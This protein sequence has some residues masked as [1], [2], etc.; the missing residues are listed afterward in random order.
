MSNERPILNLRLS[1]FTSPIENIRF[2][3]NLRVLNLENNRIKEVPDLTGLDSLA[4]L[5]LKK[6]HIEKMCDLSP[7]NHLRRLLLTDNKFQT[8][9]DLQLIGFAPRLLELNL[10][11]NAAT[12]DSFYR[13]NM[14]SR[15][16][17][18]R[19]LDG[20]RILEEERRA[21]SRLDK[22]ASEKRVE[23]EKSAM[24]NAERYRF[25]CDRCFSKTNPKRI[26]AMEK[27][28][29]MWDMTKDHPYSHIASRPETARPR[30]VS[31]LGA[32]KATS[33]M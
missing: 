11:G 5:N 17:T 26:R 19:I 25:S 29:E 30:S 16:R 7:L 15:I 6:N 3:C 9:A 27:I 10:E 2:L 20:R 32:R 21:A 22:R 12:L 28:E 24:K 4:E 1:L 18:L 8:L 31:R 23:H 13:S 33:S 14:L